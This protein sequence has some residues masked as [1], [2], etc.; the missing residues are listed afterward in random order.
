[1]AKLRTK[2]FPARVLRSGV[3]SATYLECSTLRPLRARASGDD[4]A[5]LPG[6]LRLR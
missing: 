1:M 4:C 6:R 5:Q 3:T 2:R